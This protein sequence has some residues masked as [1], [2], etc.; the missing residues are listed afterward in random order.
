MLK[1]RVDRRIN[2]SVVISHGQFHCGNI[3]YTKHALPLSKVLLSP[4]A[5]GLVE[6]QLIIH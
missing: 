3:G 5:N 2:V 4:R 1:F 6:P